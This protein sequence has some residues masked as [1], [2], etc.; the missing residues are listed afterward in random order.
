MSQTDAD[1]IMDMTYGVEM[2]LG[3]AIFPP[4]DCSRRTLSPDHMA[5]PLVS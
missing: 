5:Q 4:H 2:A 3:V 1:K